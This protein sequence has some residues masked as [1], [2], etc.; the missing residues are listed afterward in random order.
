MNMLDRLH[1][2]LLE[3]PDNA[4]TQNGRYFEIFARLH[5][6]V[7]G[8]CLLFYVPVYSV[9]GQP[10]MIGIGLGSVL[11]LLMSL[12]ALRRGFIDISAV[13]LPAALLG[14][15][16]AATLYFG[17][18]SGFSIVAVLAI[19][20]IFIAD[21][22]LMLK[23]VCSAGLLLVTLG[24]I[25][26]VQSSLPLSPL[27][28]DLRQ[29]LQLLNLVAVCTLVGLVMYHVGCVA[30]R[31][32]KLYRHSATLDS[33]TDILNR[34]GVLAEGERYHR[35]G[36]QYAVLLLDVDHFKSIN[37]TRG[38]ASGDE[39]LRHL[40]RCMKHSTRDGDAL[41][42]VG[43]EEFLILL[44]DLSIEGAVFIAERL[45]QKIE[46][47]PC[48]LPQGEPVHVTVSIGVACS[49]HHPQG[50]AAVIEQADQRLYAAKHQGRNRVVST[51]PCRL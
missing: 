2:W 47:S 17:I 26:S 44:Q 31:L 19:V 9:L 10:V 38:H 12:F 28:Y 41:G 6:V 14:Q 35:R 46:R 40:S 18:A 3:V 25:F 16:L 4:S 29:T 30:N 42:R 1:Q 37:D 32:E 45:R 39:V 21:F 33:L 20:L 22:P 11:L 51:T 24:T 43:G 34:R 5:L 27:P 49:E 23:C 36:G 48:V 13:L 50:L 15:A 7:L 8:A